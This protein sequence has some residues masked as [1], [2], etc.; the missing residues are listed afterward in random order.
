MN[1]TE[2]K[3]VDT[4]VALTAVNAEGVF[5][6]SCQRDCVDLIRRILR[7]EIRLV[8]DREGQIIQEYRRR[9][10]P[11]PS[12]D[13]GIADHFLIYAITNRTN[14]SRIVEVDIIYNP[15]I[16]RFSPYPDDVRLNGFDRN[17][18]KWIA[19]AMAYQRQ[20]GNN[21]PI[22]NATDRDWLEVNAILREYGI[23]IEFLCELD[24]R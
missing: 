18:R 9:M 17:D 19:T 23:Q 1:M 10:Y 12:P 2:D 22:V 7:S 3:I 16:D 24:E 15:E 8:I 6:I 11:T 14:R 5:S 4:N 13:A 21:A 20:M